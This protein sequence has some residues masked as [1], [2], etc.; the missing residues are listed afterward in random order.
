MLCAYWLF[1]SISLLTSIIYTFHAYK[2]KN[3]LLVLTSMIQGFLT[4]LLPFV[5]LVYISNKEWLNS[6]ENE[7]EF[8]W[9]QLLTGNSSAIFVLI[10]YVIMIFLVLSNGKSI[11]KRVHE[12]SIIF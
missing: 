5:N 10:G 6:F 7:F 11:T 8:I 2:E 3:L 4:V 1:M 9:S 12:N